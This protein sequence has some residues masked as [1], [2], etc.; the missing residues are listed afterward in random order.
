M[1]EPNERVQLGIRWTIGNVSDA[2]FEALHLSIQSCHNLFADAARYAVCVNSIPLKEAI[3]RTGELPCDIEWVRTDGWVPGWLKAHIDPDMAEGVAWKFAPV[4]LFPH[5]HELSLDNDVIFWSVPQAI[6]A[7]LQS[8]DA[9]LMGADVAPAFGQFSESCGNRSLNSGIR[10]FPPGY[11]FETDLARF[12]Q[13]SGITLRSELDEQGLQAAVLL[14]SNL[15]VVSTEDISICSPFANHQHH[16][17]TCGAHFVGLNPKTMPWII[18]GRP[19]HE[20]IREGWLSYRDEVE[21]LVMTPVEPRQSRARTG[22]M[23]TLRPLFAGPLSSAADA[24]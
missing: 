12:L 20:V 2:G 10:G 17:G 13:E 8:L 4:R 14:R 3:T 23:A 1:N 7:W 18:D 5:L 15:Y 22:A 16:L 9:C 19:A 11:D 24:P 21:A 6:D